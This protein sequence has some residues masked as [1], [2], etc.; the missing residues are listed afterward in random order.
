MQA[1]KLGTN[2]DLQVDPYDGREKA[3]VILVVPVQRRLAKHPLRDLGSRRSTAT[4][5]AARSSGS[6]A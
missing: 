3:V 5:L 4:F 1:V 6:A 2:K